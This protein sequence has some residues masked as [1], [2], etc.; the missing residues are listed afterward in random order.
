MNNPRRIN[1]VTQPHRP[2]V[3]QASL[4]LAFFLAALSL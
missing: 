3:A 4:V 2:G 1:K